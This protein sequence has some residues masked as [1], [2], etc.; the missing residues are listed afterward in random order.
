MKKLII[1][2]CTLLLIVGCGPKVSKEIK[3][4]CKSYLSVVD[5][6]I[7]GEK[8]QMDAYWDLKEFYDKINDIRETDDEFTVIVYL[9]SVDSLLMSWTLASDNPI[10]ELKTRRNKLAGSCGVK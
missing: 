6:V 7:A 9:M 5:K 2:F 8:D 3:S 4:Y 1:L 10:E